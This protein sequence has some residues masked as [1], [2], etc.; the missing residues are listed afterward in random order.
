MKTSA[1]ACFA[2]LC[3]P[4]IFI[5]HLRQRKWLA[6]YFFVCLTYGLPFFTFMFLMNDGS[7]VWGQSLLIA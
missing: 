5:R 3:A 2:S 7:A 6:A 1:C 4:I